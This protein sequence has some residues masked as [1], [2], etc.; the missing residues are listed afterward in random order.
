MYWPVSTPRVFTLPPIPPAESTAASNASGENYSTSNDATEPIL[1]VKLSRNGIL[2]GVITRTS[3]YVY[4]NRPV[5]PVAVAV[6]SESS[7]Q[8]YGDNVHLLIR[9]DNVMFVVQTSL[10]YFLTYALNG[11]NAERVRVAKLSFD[12]TADIPYV[13]PGPGEEQ[14]V[15]EENIRFRMVIKVDA[16]IESAIALEEELLVLTT[17]PPAAQLIRWTPD[18][19]GGPQTRT[20]LLSHMEWFNLRERIT[21][22][23]FERAMG[24]FGWISSNGKAWAVVKHNTQVPSIGEKPA[25][26]KLFS[27]YCF[28]SPQKG[29]IPATAAERRKSMDESEFVLKIA[30]NSRFSLIGVGTVGGTIHIYNVKDYSG[31]IPLLR[32]I[33]SPFP[34]FG[35]VT[36]IAWSPDGYSLFAGYERGWALYSVYGK[37]VAHSILAEDGKHQNE[38]WLCGIQ[39]AIWMSNGGDILVVPNESNELWSIEVARWSLTGS[40]NWDNLARTLLFTN[41]KLM[42]YRGQ[43]QSDLTTIS[44][45][46]ILWQDVAIPYAYLA[47]NWPVQQTCISGDGRYLAIAGKR[48]LGHYS[49]YSG[50]WKFFASEH[51]ENEFSVHG[52]MLWFENILIACVNTDRNTHEIRAYSRERE[53]DHSL[54]LHVQQIPSSIILISLVGDSLLVYTYSNTLYQFVISSNAFQ[55]NLE[56]VGQISFIGIVHA[57]ARVRAINWI[58]PEEQLENGNP[59]HDISLATIVFLIDGKLVLLYPL[60]NDGDLKYDMKVLLQNVEYYTIVTKGLLKN[61]IW[62]FDGTSV[63]VW[64]EVM[65]N[66]SRSD[67][68]PVPIRIDID[69]YPLSF[70]FEKGII[71][72]IESNLIHR[73]NVSFTYSANTTRTHLFIHQLLRYYLTSSQESEA[74]K[75]AKSFQQLEYFGH[76]LEMMLHDVLDEEADHPPSPDQA[77]LP[78]VIKFLNNFPEMLDVIAGCTRKTEVASWHVLFD[79]VGSPKELFE[80]CMSLGQLKTAGGYLL[81]LHTMEQ[82]EDSS[83]DMIRLFSTA[84]EIGDWDLCKELARFLT[85]LDNSGNTLR[86]ALRRM[87]LMNGV[88]SEVQ[89]PLEREFLLGV[90]PEKTA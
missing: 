13:L 4:Q 67:S 45:E 75:V 46:A 22:I 40:Y 12:T 47:E 51:M 37:L 52:G 59:V 53:L 34:P 7:L 81:I 56:L 80:K 44:H 19:R 27:G 69:F 18:A 6:R 65:L 76:A 28:H 90:A 87:K 1:T 16:G 48:G 20:E 5:C 3:L 38:A 86:E 61:S 84:V 29:P 82:L 30:I 83:T 55:F 57:P 25:K 33:K 49:I 17:T 21:T 8:T 73:R 62:A 2:F 14:G 15:R 31:H 54:V 36:V 89:S 32:D 39:D 23:V 78:R 60:H 11:S 71:I 41:E 58:L 50:R 63:V 77:I 85:A 10:G 64:L 70:L 66:L 26:V 72:G 88:D 74:L 9:P 24:L 43:D 68:V 42:L 79:I 35:K